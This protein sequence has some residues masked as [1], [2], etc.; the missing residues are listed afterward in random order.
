MNLKSIL[1][2]YKFLNKKHLTVTFSIVYLQDPI[3][4]YRRPVINKQLS[5]WFEGL[6]VTRKREDIS[7]LLKDLVEKHFPENLPLPD[8]PLPTLNGKNG[9]NGIK[10]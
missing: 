4:D 10:W 1:S 5:S 8:I 9:I 2:R 3:K 6:V 7:N